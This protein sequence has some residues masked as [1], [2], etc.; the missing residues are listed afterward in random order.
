MPELQLLLE[1]DQADP[2]LLAE[3]QAALTGGT[4]EGPRSPEPGQARPSSASEAKAGKNAEAESEEEQAKS[5]ARSGDQE[6]GQ[7]SAPQPAEGRSR[8][9]KLRQRPKSVARDARGQKARGAKGPSSILDEA[10]RREAAVRQASGSAYERR[11]S[12]ILEE[13]A[14]RKARKRQR[15][16]YILLAVLVLILCIWFLP[17]FRV[18]EVQVLG[19]GER[20]AQNVRETAAVRPGQHLLAGLGPSPWKLLTLR[21]GKLEEKILQTYPDLL[22]VTVRPALP[23]TLRIRVERRI[24]IACLAL[25]SGE[26]A[27]IDKTGTVVRILSPEEAAG[28]PVIQDLSLQSARPGQQLGDKLME[29]LRPQI[30]VLSAIINSGRG[31]KSGDFQLLSHV[32]R[33]GHYAN[34]QRYMDL[35]GEDLGEG[36]RVLLG[37]DAS[38]GDDMIWL[39]YVLR[40]GKLK[41]LSNGILDLSSSRKIFRAYREE[42]KPTASSSQG[43]AGQTATQAGSNPTPGGNSATGAAAAPTQTVAQNPVA[44]AVEPVASAP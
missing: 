25:D 44:A 24:A 36:L 2:E 1:A 18:Q 30:L 8:E 11:R 7:R 12:Q 31:D 23:G 28:M 13:A 32:T 26:R 20:E 42:E 16:R 3:A 4:A 9:Q 35:T 37:D 40:N 38:L 29:E 5:Q 15:R 21:W 17:F 19:L 27:L 6:R 41:N 43:S 14:E 33:L 39:R 10:R 22:H 34:R